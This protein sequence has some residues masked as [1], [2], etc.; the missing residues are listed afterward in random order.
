[1]AEDSV[2]ESTSDEMEVEIDALALEGD[3]GF[4][5]H[6]WDELLSDETLDL[7]ELACAGIKGSETSFWQPA[8]APA[9]TALEHFALSVWAFH[10]GARLPESCDLA[11]SGLEYW[12]QRRSSEQP[13]AE[14]SINFH[15]DKDEEIREEHGLFVHPHISTVTYLRGAGAPTVVLPV[16]IGFDGSDA[17]TEPPR[18]TAVGAHGDSDAA[19]H[20]QLR[21]RECMP[22]AIVSYP[23]RR[24]HL[25]FDGRLLHGCPVELTFQKLGHNSA[26]GITAVYERLTVLVNIWL[27]HHPSGVERAPTPAKN[28]KRARADASDAALAGALGALPR[29]GP[30]ALEALADTAAHEGGAREEVPLEFPVGDSALARATV[31]TGALRQLLQADAAGAPAAHVPIEIRIEECA[32]ETGEEGEEGEEGEAGEDGEDGDGSDSPAAHE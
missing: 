17:R 18:A 24:R 14:Q 2:L 19:A 10:M 28:G 15:F 12:V 6:V 23:R 16:R 9:R 21:V 13:T 3:C 26:A 22:H 1:M 4:D 11:R 7:L 31:A 8:D 29:A 27:N 30:S 32:S 20:A 25:A 5:A